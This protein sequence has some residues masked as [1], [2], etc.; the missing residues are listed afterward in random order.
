MNINQEIILNTE[1]LHGR[2]VVTVW[3]DRPGYINAS[4]VEGLADMGLI[5]I[6]EQ[7]DSDSIAAQYG[8]VNFVFTK[9]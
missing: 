6:V 1:P 5:T 7:S 9:N 3:A 4:D 8:R 2:C